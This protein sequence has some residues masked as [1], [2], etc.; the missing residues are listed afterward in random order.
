M[1][2]SWIRT[3][4]F[5]NLVPDT[6]CL[7]E[8]VNVFFGLNAQGKTNLLEAVA[9]LAD[10]RSFRGARIA[11]MIRSGESDACIE[12]QVNSDTTEINLKIYM[13]RSSRQYHIDDRSVSDLREFLGRFSYVVYASECMAIVEGDP[14]ARRH[15]LDHGYFGLKPSYLLTLRS[16]RKI[17]KSRNATIKQA[18]DNERLITAWNEPLCRYGASITCSRRTYLEQ[19]S[20]RAEEGYRV[21]ANDTEKLT[22]EYSSQWLTKETLATNDEK[23]IY[24][25]M[26]AGLEKEI[27]GDIRRG[28]TLIGPHRDELRILIDG[29][30]IRW[31]GSRGQKR[32]A[33]MAMKLAELEV[34]HAARN[35]YP[36]LI[37]DDMSSEFDQLR[38][39]SLIQVLPENMQI[40]ISHTEEF[41]DHFDQPVQYFKVTGGGVTEC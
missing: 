19:I 14:A 8:G 18:P 7:A 21:L 1:R 4:G 12:G 2:L 10:G 23:N 28:S 34:F 11:E 29:Y 30:D 16:Y 39:G 35:D 17:L 38:Q 26:R 33:L 5:R 13:N 31:F 25:E 32:T 9:L 36:V 37:L 27:S 41:Q 24:E 40:L 3:S 22:I 20:R 6:V 15:F